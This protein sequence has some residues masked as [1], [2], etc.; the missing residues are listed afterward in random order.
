M[1]NHRR[2]WGW[3][4][5]AALAVAVAAS[6]LFRRCADT[7]SGPVPAAVDSSAVSVPVVRDTVY[8]KIDGETL[9]IVREQPVET[10]GT[11]PGETAGEASVETSGEAAGETSAS[12]TPPAP[13]AAETV[14]TVPVKDVVRLLRQKSGRDI[15]LSTQ[16]P[17]RISVSYVGK[18]QLPVV[19]EQEMDLSTSFRIVGVDGDHLSLQLDNGA[20][21]N[22]AA[23][24]IVPS[25]LERL[26]AGIVESYSKGR[27]VV[28]LSAVP[29]LKKQLAE[30]SLTGVSVD[31]D[32]IKLR[33]VKK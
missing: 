32:A 19:G 33:T 24:L 8:V 14:I 30:V 27:A 6:L 7:P 5:V 11:V 1:G 17:D 25:L 20:A 31:E 9:P 2:K 18:V 4:L 12:A 15:G 22:A 23:D 29:G 16:S 10:P 3:W 13:V 21:K 28:N 26:P